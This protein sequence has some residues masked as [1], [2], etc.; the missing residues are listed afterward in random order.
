MDTG[1]PAG[2]QLE[3]SGTERREYP[4]LRSERG[5]GGVEAV[6]EGRH[7]TERLEV[8]AL[9]QLA[10]DHRRVAGADPHQ[11]AVPMRRHQ[12]RVGR[13]RL[14]GRVHPQVEDAG[15]HGDRAGRR[16]EPLDGAEDVTPGVGD[17]QRRVPELFELG[18]GLG[19]LTGIPE[20]QPDVPHPDS[21]DSHLTLTL[22]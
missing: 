12:T 17:P 22:I 1:R 3:H 13:R 6:E 7:G 18:R 21:A 5:A 8:A 20:A 11:E 19:R 10:V 16:Q 2:R 9:A 4:A 15:G 14:L